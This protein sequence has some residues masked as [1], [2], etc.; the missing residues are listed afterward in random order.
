MKKRA[1]VKFTEE[2]RSSTRTGTRP[3]SDVQSSRRVPRR[4]P[5]ATSTP[6]AD[7]AQVATPNIR[8][9]PPLATPVAFLL[10]NRHAARGSAA[11]CLSRWG[12]DGTRTSF[13]SGNFIAPHLTPVMPSEEATDL[14]VRIEAPAHRKQPRFVQAPP[15][16]RVYRTASY[17]IN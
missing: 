15:T 13:H 10:Q 17:A 3:G 12:A 8:A 5:A 2:I 11:N 4:A 7:R 6:G 16:R 1:S 9:F 14:S